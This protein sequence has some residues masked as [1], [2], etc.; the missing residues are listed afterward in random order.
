MIHE[1]QIWTALAGLRTGNR[2]VN[3]FLQMSILHFLALRRE[4]TR[5]GHVGQG[6]G[7]T[8][9]PSGDLPFPHPQSA[10][11]NL[12]NFGFPLFHTVDAL[13]L[14]PS[15]AQPNP[16]SIPPKLVILS[17]SSPPEEGEEGIGNKIDPRGECVQRA[18]AILFRW[19]KRERGIECFVRH[20][21]APPLI[22][23]GP[24]L[25]PRSLPSAAVR[26]AAAP[27]RPRSQVRPMP[28]N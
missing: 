11:F 17:R 10:P 15:P 1:P 21:W 20:T 12:N 13:S 24:P 8:R 26:V 27:N 3:N 7:R 22:R 9:R 28:E 6:S 2:Q 4:S 16:T 18:A 23:R 19:A 14:P 5:M 25:A